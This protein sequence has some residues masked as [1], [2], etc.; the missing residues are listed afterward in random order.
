MIF[1]DMD[2][3]LTD[4]H[5]AA[6]H[7]IIG[8]EQEA[9]NLYE[10]WPYNEFDIAKVLGISQSN[11]WAMLDTFEFW[12][13]MPKT[14]QCDTLLRLFPDA[15]ILSS[16]AMG[17][18]ASGKVA[19]LHKHARG[20]K[21]ILTKHKEYIAGEGRILIDDWQ[22]NIDKW[23]KHNGQGILFPARANVL[24]G[25]DPLAHVMHSTQELFKTK[26]TNEVRSSRDDFV[27]V[28]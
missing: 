27:S 1:L 5:R 21:F 10:N 15:V 6:L 28:R 22:E 9:S 7:V 13:D 12:A 14:Q 16:P 3:V 26:V 24:H 2:G 20:R 25:I 19:W 4:F 18:S 11:F 23:T 17:Y 8:N